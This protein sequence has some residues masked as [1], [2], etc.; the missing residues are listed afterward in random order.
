MGHI[1]RIIAARRIMTTLAQD[2]A[3]LR[4]M[5]EEVAEIAKRVEIHVKSLTRDDAAFNAHGAIAGVPA[6][7][8][9]AAGFTEELARELTGGL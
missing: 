8:R 7:L 5:A 6:N 4:E 3:R 1:L 2:A 9:I